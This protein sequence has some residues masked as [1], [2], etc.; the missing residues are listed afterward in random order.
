[1]KIILAGGSG[2][3][4][5]ALAAYFMNHHWEVVIL[6]RSSVEGRAGRQVQWDGKDLG[7]WT[8]ELEGAMCVVN[9]AGKSVDC[10]YTRRNREEILDSRLLPTT[11]LGKAIE[12]CDNP[13]PVWVNLSTATIYK[14]TFGA[15][16]DESGT[17]G[18]TPEAKDA[19]SIEVATR[20][21]EAFFKSNTPQTRKIAL[22]LA[23]VLGHGRNSVFPT[24]I[25]LTRLG[26]GGDMA[27]GRQFVSWIHVLDFCRAVHRIIRDEAFEGVVNVAAPNPLTNSE[28]MRTMRRTAGMPIGLPAPL[29]LL[30]LGAFFLRT[31]TEL[32]I[33]SR[34]VIP[35][36]LLKGGFEFLYPEFSGAVANLVRSTA[37]EVLVERTKPEIASIPSL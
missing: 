24:L 8:Q 15:A 5:Q 4:G 33:K 22:R 12:R 7:A 36:R 35:D 34:R 3:L 30:E 29:P 28:M 25:R 19:F 6:A 10:R 13:P 9:L 31:E 14:H 37:A 2:F 23:M 11:L 21:E 18:A 26:L 32:I 20:W 17:I 16:W 1:M 27:G